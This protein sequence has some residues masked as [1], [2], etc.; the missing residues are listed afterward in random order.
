MSR[1]NLETVRRAITAT[2]GTDR[3]WETINAVYDRDHVFVPITAGLGDGEIAGAAEARKWFE[4]QS[5]IT[6][7]EIDLDGVLSLGPDLVLAETTAHVRGVG[8]GAEGD[9]KIWLV[10][11][12]KRGRIART[13]GF[14]SPSD[15]AAEAAR[16]AEQARSSAR[17]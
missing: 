3:D 8:S 1:E 11:T 13:Q 2:S 15:A 9:Q 10:L 4:D 14:L 17:S 6:T 7:W 5:N 16:L 12:F